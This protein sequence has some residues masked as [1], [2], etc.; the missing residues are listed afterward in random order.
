MDTGAGKQQM[1]SSAEYEFFNGFGGF[2]ND[3]SEYEIV[4]T[5]QKRPPV[6]WINV[7]ANKK[8]GFQ[9]SESGGGFT[10]AINSR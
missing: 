5:G 6:P 10:W 4:L 8:F 2:I 1:Q 7:V 9:I 3:G